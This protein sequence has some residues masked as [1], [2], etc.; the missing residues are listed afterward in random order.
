MNQLLARIQAKAFGAEI[1]DSICKG[2]L[3]FSAMTILTGFSTLPQNQQLQEKLA[4]AREAARENKL[5]LMQYQW[6]ETTQLTLKGDQKPPRQYL[7]QYGSDGQ[8]QKPPS[9]L[10]PKGRAEAG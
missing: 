7:C 9:V 6:T 4:I 10:P 2:F 1:A 5:R 3:I 8:V